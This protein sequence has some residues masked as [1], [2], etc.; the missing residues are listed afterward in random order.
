MSDEPTDLWNYRA[1]FEVL[2]ATVFG[3]RELK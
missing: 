3:S 1:Y 2:E